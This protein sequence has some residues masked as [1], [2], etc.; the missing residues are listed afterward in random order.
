MLV[1]GAPARVQAV[2]EFLSTPEG[3]QRWV[4]RPAA[5]SPPTTTTPSGL[6]RR[7]LQAAGCCRHPRPDATAVGFDASDLM[8]AAV[9]SGS[10]WTE[11]DAWVNGGGQNPIDRR[12]PRGHRRQPGQ[13][14]NLRPI[15]L[16][17]AGRV[18]P[19]GEAPR[20]TI[21][22]SAGGAH[23][24]SSSD[25]E[26]AAS[27][28]IRPAHRRPHRL[29]PRASAESS[30]WS[31]S[32][33]SSEPARLDLRP[34]RQRHGRRPALR[35]GQGDQLLAK[36]LLALIALVVGVGGIWLLFIGVGW[37][38]EL[39]FGPSGATESCPRGSSL[40]PA[41]ALARRRISLYPA[42]GTPCWRCLLRHAT[43]AF[44]LSRNYIGPDDTGLR[45]DPAQQRHLA[46]RRHRRQR[47]ARPGHRRAV[48]PRAPRGPG[49][50]VHLPAAR[51]LAHRRVGHLE[52]HVH[53]AASR[54]AAD[55][56]C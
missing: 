34:A 43:G 30:F 24:R 13:P 11:M 15:L 54:Q 53:V 40:R 55:T 48:R 21:P 5:P 46:D 6:V 47:V 7:Q 1:D 9:G 14:S 50:D 31:T 33:G 22:A 32:M 38:V 17:S 26:N 28:S 2:A 12:D 4:R 27:E 18:A 52:L 35:N 41:L 36:I 51:H 45:R 29:R 39:S 42:V 20:C 16:C 3:T 56:A 23:G 37:L 8:P 19:T 25:N 49:Q 44:T 10:F